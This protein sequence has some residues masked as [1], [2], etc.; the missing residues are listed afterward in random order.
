MSIKFRYV[1][2]AET[3]VSVITCGV[4]LHMHRNS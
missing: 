1:L 4:E 3:N 2:S